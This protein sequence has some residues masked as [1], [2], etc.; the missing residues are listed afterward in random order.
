[1]DITGKVKI[2]V[3]AAVFGLLAVSRVSA[4]VVVPSE[5]KGLQNTLREVAKQV[6]PSVVLVYVEKK[7]D[8]KSGGS[9]RGYNFEFPFDF[10]K[11]FKD[12]ED[13]EEESPSQNRKIPQ[14][15]ATGMGSGFIITQDGWVV[16]NYHVVEDATE[17][18]V[19]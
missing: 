16:T 5:V 3:L 18:K 10:R 14:P 12:G 19:T 1:M 4:K 2:T 15:K 8:V 9:G 11:F 17:V 6:N 13:G 7:V